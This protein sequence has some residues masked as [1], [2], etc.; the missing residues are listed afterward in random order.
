MVQPEKNGNAP[1]K[2]AKNSEKMQKIGG[3][4]PGWAEISDFRF[5]I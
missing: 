1:E 4:M 5:D 3:E 2:T